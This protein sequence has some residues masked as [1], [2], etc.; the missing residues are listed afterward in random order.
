MDFLNK[1]KIY[2]TNILKDK[3]ALEY[4]GHF[5]D[6]DSKRYI[7]RKGKKTPT[8]TGYFVTFY[9]R[10]KINMPFDEKDEFDYF[11]IYVKDEENEILFSIPK[12]DLLQLGYISKEDKGGKMAF[13]IYAPWNQNLNDQA[14]KTFEKQKKFILN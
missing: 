14:T 13:R 12:T 4:S 3:N 2:P 10:I 6:F 9:K 1:Y 7:F 11:L 8:K 5:F